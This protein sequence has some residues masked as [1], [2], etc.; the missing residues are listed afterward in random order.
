[1][2]F[3]PSRKDTRPVRLTLEEVEPAPAE[4]RR[5]PRVKLGVP[6]ML[7]RKDAPPIPC[8]VADSS[9]GGVRLIVEET[10]PVASI[11][12]VVLCFN[13]YHLRMK[14]Q[15]DWVRGEDGKVEVGA[16]QLA[17]PHQDEHIAEKFARYLDW[18]QSQVA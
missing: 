6:T 5:W 11:A 10:L 2:N 4:N 8:F 3:W 12:G 17:G 14:L 1:M 16:H 7:Y 15:V 13:G 18:R 9:A